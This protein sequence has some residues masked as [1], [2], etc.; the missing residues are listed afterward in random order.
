MSKK[1]L[2]KHFKE[3]GVIDNMSVKLRSGEMPDFYC[4]VKKAYGHWNI[5]N[6]IANGIGKLL[7][8]SVTCVAASGHGGLPI[9]SIVAH[10][11]KKHFV[12]VR[13]IPKSHG[14]R[15][16][17]DGFMPGKNDQIVIIDDVLTTG[18]SIC[19]TL[20]VL[21]GTKAKVLNAIVIVKRGDA[22]LPIP[23][24]FLLTV[25]DIKK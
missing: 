14:R 5:T 18:S 20:S 1:I 3:I 17:I 21:K 24:S 25:E 8:K 23:Y 2:I 19:K 9:A 13:D 7:P 12:A 11:F 10:K 4:D 16:L 6:V 15:N 22:K